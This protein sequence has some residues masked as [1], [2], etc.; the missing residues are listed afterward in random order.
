MTHYPMAPVPL[1]QDLHHTLPL[2]NQPSLSRLRLTI[3]R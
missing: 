3:S 1:Q 2:A